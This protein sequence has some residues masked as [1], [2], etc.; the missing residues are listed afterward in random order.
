MMRLVSIAL[1][2]T[3]SL[4]TACKKDDKKPEE[5]G[6]AAKTE[7]KTEEKKAAPAGPKEMTAEAFVTD[8]LGEKDGMALLDR[9]RD[10]IVVTGNVKQ[11]IEEMDG[12]LA[13]W[14]DAGNPKYVSLGFKDQGA[15]AK[16][17]GLKQGD[18]VKARCQVGGGMD[19]YVMVT[20]CELL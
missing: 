12:S 14:L 2:A 17:K 20:D 18:A 16:S 15:A 5:G 7:E 1:I 3:L 4:T 11:T 9:Y 6:P 13:V 19:N 10:G 8:F